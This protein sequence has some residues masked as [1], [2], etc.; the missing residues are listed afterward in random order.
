M[1]WLRS[2]RPTFGLI[3]ASALW[4]FDTMSLAVFIGVIGL[5]VGPDFLDGLRRTGWAVLFVG[6]LVA[7][8]PNIVALL[9]FLDKTKGWTPLVRQPLSFLSFLVPNS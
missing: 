6:L 5:D 2:V 8:V 3:P 1:P 7:V 4:V 9:C